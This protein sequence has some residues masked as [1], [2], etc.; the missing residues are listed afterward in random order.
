MRGK[1]VLNVPTIHQ[2]PEYPTGCESVAAVMALRYAGESTSVAD[3]IDNHLPCSQEFYWYESKFYG[4]SP[5]EYFLGDP[6]SE[7]S[8]GCMAPVIEKALI[9]FLSSNERVVN[10]TGQTLD[11]LCETYIDN[12]TPV[13]VWASINMVAIK[14]GREWIL[15]D[16][17]TYTWPSN[18]HCLLLVG[19]DADRYYFNDPYTGRVT[20]YARSIVEQRYEQL[21]KQSL[22][23]TK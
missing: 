14:D 19:Y 22:V 5:Y 13:I 17:S 10:T 9:S 11:E 4:P 18:E 2:F 7:N 8:Y 6:R 16:G 23:V 3:F 15:P 21:G 1:A 12:D 20:S